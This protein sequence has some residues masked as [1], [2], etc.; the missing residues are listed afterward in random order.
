MALRPVYRGG[1]PRRRWPDD[2]FD[3]HELIKWELRGGRIDII[4]LDTKSA[5]YNRGTA[6]EIR[7]TI[8]TRVFRPTGKGLDY[9]WEASY[10]WGSSGSDSIRAWS[11]ST[12][13]GFTFDRIRFH[14]RPLL[15]ADVYSGDGNPA[16]QTLGTFNPLFRRGAYFSPKT[17]PLLGPQNLIYLHI[18]TFGHPRTRSPYLHVLPEIGASKRTTSAIAN[19]S[20]H[21]RNSAALFRNSSNISA[22]LAMPRVRCRSSSSK[23][24]KEC[25]GA[26][27]S[28]CGSTAAMPRV[29]GW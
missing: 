8:G 14:P 27:T 21:S 10:Q 29:I 9:N 17:V 6:H 28:T 25:P 7:N 11:V 18:P 26:K 24:F 20:P 15:R 3:Q 4:G 19:D 1:R 5:T 22:Y 13:T 2:P 12:E 23:L 16:N